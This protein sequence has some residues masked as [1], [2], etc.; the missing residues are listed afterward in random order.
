MTVLNQK[1]APRR[2]SE[3]TLPPASFGSHTSKS[4]SPSLAM[5]SAAVSMAAAAAFTPA[6]VDPQLLGDEMN[7][8][9]IAQA[10]LLE[11]E[12]AALNNPMQDQQ[13]DSRP[14]A[15]TWPMLDGTGGN[16][17]PDPEAYSNNIQNTRIPELA[18]TNG[19][20]Q[21]IVMN[22]ANMTTEFSAEYGNGKR[23][24]KP[25]VRG[26]F[27]ATR[28]K[29]V[30]EVRKR[31][32]CIRC[33]MLKKPCSG[34]SPCSTC[35]NVESARLWKQPCVR[36]RI[37]DE[38]DM[39]SAG[40]HAVLAYHE[41]SQAKGRVKLRSSAS[42]IQATHF[43][44]TPIFATFSALQADNMMMGDNI[45]PSLGLSGYPNDSS[46]LRLLDNEGDD[47]PMKLEAYMKRMSS[48]YFERETSPFMNTT[49]NIALELSIEKQDGLLTRVLELWATVHILVDHEL[50]WTLTENSPMMSE[51]G[52]EIPIDI[53]NNHESYHLI[54]SQ[55]NAAA[56]K[57]AA[58]I[59]KIVLND[60]ERR[61]LQRTST[62]SF[63]T[64]LVAIILLNCV[65][66]SS[67][68]FKSWEQ[69]AF[70]GK[71][72]LDK[73]PLW[74]GSQGDR[75]ADML[76]ML[77]RMRG[78][79]PKTYHRVSDGILATDGD[80][81]ARLYFERLQLPCKSSG[82]V[83]VLPECQLTPCRCRRPEQAE[84]SYV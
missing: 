13:F 60:L 24:N 2:D 58:Q 54:C 84:Q 22:A 34:E 83:L 19:F 11:S 18:T 25:K 68:L 6:M 10:S 70:K 28:R 9:A 53:A 59:S 14:Q 73:T 1:L 8:G 42:H 48:V 37:A 3:N 38:L 29:E 45:D 33:R 44:N 57:K 55:L 7:H 23:P 66:K 80:E 4:P 36:T 21:P 71:W 31:G 47:L 49:L 12:V 77:L 43:P 78:I 35:R 15:P 76:Q 69:D 81:V 27:T 30:Q 65:E 51:I 67:W 16:M 79:P 82:F 41:I 20:P 26:R 39:Y 72:P 17:Y 50:R 32:A 46:N 40:L 52:Q 5:S 63:E 64:F 74:Y 62:S 61:L 56:E 75:I